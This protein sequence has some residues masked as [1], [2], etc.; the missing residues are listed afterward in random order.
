MRKKSEKIRKKGKRRSGER[1]RRRKGREKGQDNGWMDG[2]V[3]PLSLVYCYMNTR[4]DACV[5][6]TPGWILYACVLAWMLCLLQG[7]SISRGVSSE[8]ASYRQKGLLTTVINKSEQAHNVD[9]DV[10][11]VVDASQIGQ[12]GKKRG[13]GMAWRKSPQIVEG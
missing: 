11:L 7:I 12:R 10:A 1:G 6:C 8:V 2:D 9:R 4:M 3:R 13:Y 5:N